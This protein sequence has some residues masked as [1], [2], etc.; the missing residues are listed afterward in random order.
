MISGVYSDVTVNSVET[1]CSEFP[2]G[3]VQLSRNRVST[4]MSHGLLD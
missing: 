4:F 2:R 3:E 1:Y